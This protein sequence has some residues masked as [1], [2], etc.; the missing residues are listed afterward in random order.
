[1]TTSAER[2]EKEAK[3]EAER[4]EVERKKQL[5]ERQRI[6]QN[7]QARDKR[8]KECDASNDAAEYHHYQDY[9]NTLK[10]LLDPN[11]MAVD[12][13][14]TSYTMNL[15]TGPNYRKM[16]TC[17][18]LRLKFKNETKYQIE[19]MN[20]GYEKNYK[21]SSDQ[22]SNFT[23]YSLNPGEEYIKDVGIIRIDDMRE[24]CTKVNR[25][26]LKKKPFIPKKC[27]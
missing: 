14:C 10:S 11:I 2:L 4:L 19:S 3:E 16:T 1:M 17:S 21:C 6:K 26:S 7:Q 23:V 18:S 5:V 9:N 8:K 22:Y 13:H 25:V 24:F 20:F 15:T 12:Y 27:L